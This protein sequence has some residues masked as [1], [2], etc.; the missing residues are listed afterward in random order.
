MSEV[1]S[2]GCGWRAIQVPS[3]DLFATSSLVLVDAPHFCASAGENHPGF[4]LRRTTVVYPKQLHS[5]AADINEPGSTVI[6]VVYVCVQP[7]A[8]NSTA[9]TYGCYYWCC[10]TQHR[11]RRK[12]G[13]NESH[14]GYALLGYRKCRCVCSVLVARDRRENRNLF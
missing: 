11:S 5:H 1:G 14:A 10:R 6:H 3:F 7:A 13:Q 9:A 2:S 12:G 8:I 4:F